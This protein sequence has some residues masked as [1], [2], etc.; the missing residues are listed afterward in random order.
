M[1]CKENAEKETKKTGL[2]K[3]DVNDKVKCCK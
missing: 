2:Q 1:T 3:K